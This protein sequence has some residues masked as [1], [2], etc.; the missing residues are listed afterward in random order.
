[1]GMS[2]EAIKEHEF[3]Q[4]EVKEIA[5]GFN[6]P[7]YI[8]R[9]LC[10]KVGDVDV[11]EKVLGTNGP[12]DYLD[13]VRR[14]ER[15]PKQQ[16]NRFDELARGLKK[17]CAERT[18]G[19]YVVHESERDEFRREKGIRI[20][21]TPIDS[22]HTAVVLKS[23]SEFEDHDSEAPGPVR[24]NELDELRKKHDEKRRQ[25]EYELKRFDP[26]WQ[27]LERERWQVEKQ[28]VKIYRDFLEDEPKQFQTKKSKVIRLKEAFPYLRVSTDL[29]AKVADCSTGYAKQFKHIDGEG[30]ADSEANSKLKKDVLRRD[31]ERCVSCGSTENLAVHHIIPRNQG[32]ANESE[33]LATLC[34]SCHH[35]AHGG[36]RKE[37][38]E[39]FQAA[40]YGSVEYSS[41]EEFWNNWVDQ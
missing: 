31:E 33:N 16:S 19:V 7:L 4:E 18:D 35:R 20:Q 29:I 26:V 3:I 30:I 21:L 27:E 11:L 5:L 15:I 8:S 14:R 1:M 13:L 39:G 28:L 37:A 24:S 9:R 10:D 12:P 34:Q 2:R 32:G 22:E 41:V 38:D 25:V 23:E 6:L 36:R 17:W 40:D